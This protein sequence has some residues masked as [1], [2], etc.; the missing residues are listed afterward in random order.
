MHLKR[1]GSDKEHRE[2]KYWIEKLMKIIIVLE[3]G[4]ILTPFSIRNLVF[5][6]ISKSRKRLREQGGEES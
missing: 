2:A 6:I 4:V 1:L 5:N 3:L